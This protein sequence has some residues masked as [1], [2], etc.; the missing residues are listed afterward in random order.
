MWAL[1]DKPNWVGE[2]GVQNPQTEHYPELFHN[3]IWAAL[4]A[5]AALT[6]AEWNDFDSWG[7]MTTKIKTHMRFFNEFV[8]T[9]PLAQ[10]APEPLNINSKNADVRG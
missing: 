3:A 7:A 2:F 4:G 6:P 10:W 1:E 8:A 9:V 5:G